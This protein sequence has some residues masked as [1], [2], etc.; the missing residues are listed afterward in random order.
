VMTGVPGCGAVD[1]PAGS[2]VMK[3]SALFAGSDDW[4]VV[5]ERVRAAVRAGSILEESITITVG[6]EAIVAERM[7]AIARRLPE[8]ALVES[9]L[10]AGEL[11]VVTNLQQ[12]AEGGRVRLVGD[13]SEQVQG[14]K[15]ATTP[16]GGG[17]K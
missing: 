17:A 11:L 15:P 3:V 12:V 4:E 16:A 10:A 9:G 6:V 7:P 13:A 5:T 2:G 14:P 8:V 1:P